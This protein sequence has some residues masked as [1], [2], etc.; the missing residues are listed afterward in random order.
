MTAAIAR[1]PAGACDCHVHVFG[2]ASD[3]PFDPARSYTPGDATLADLV[4]MHRGVGIARTVIV[5]PSPYGTDN[6]CLLHALEQ[7]AGAGRGVAVIDDA[8]S[9]VQFQAMHRAGVR[10][11]RVNLETAGQHDPEVA[12][13]N[14]A[15]AA[16]RVAP[17]GWHVQTY[18]NLATIAALAGALE[19]IPVTLVVD[20]FGRAQAAAGVS[21]PGFD[22]LL[23]AVAS[24]RAY[25]KLSAAYRISTA[26]DY[27]DAEPIAR[28]LI[29]ANPDRVLWGSDWPHPGSAAGAPRPVGDITPFRQEDNARALQR[30]MQWAGTAERIDKLLVENPARLYDF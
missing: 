24:G 20:H 12:W 9:D 28:A 15:R 1:P 25:V 7:L 8:T 22:A 6:T 17:L 23:A 11:V 29:D 2:P 21:Q 5:Q 3:F 14:L 10:G 16:E 13:R 19:Q 4:R 26:P 30:A 18:T 27:R